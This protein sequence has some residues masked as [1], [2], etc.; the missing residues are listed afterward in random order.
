MR[1][2]P[3]GTRRGSPGGESDRPMPDAAAPRQHGAYMERPPPPSTR[4]PFTLLFLAA[5][6]LVVS[7][8]FMPADIAG[9]TLVSSGSG[10]EAAFV[11]AGVVLIAA[12]R[13]DA[14]TST[15]RFGLALAAVGFVQLAF[16]VSALIRPPTG[17]M[18]PSGL[19]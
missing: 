15:R 1:T 4:A 2:R 16:F 6:L 10:A 12:R 13:P 7:H 18:G 17:P 3:K 14:W 5:V 11:A 8:A 9:R 19:I